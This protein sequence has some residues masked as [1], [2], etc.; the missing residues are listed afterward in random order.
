MK[1]IGYYV[2]AALMAASFSTTAMTA[3][4]QQLEMSY[5]AGVT[6]DYVWRGISQT[7]EGPAAQAG[8]DAAY[9]LFYAGVWGSNVDF[10]DVGVAS[11]SADWEV[12]LVAG[13]KPKLGM[14]DFDLGLIYYMYP[15]ASDAAAEYN[16]LELKAGVSTSIDKL[17]VG[18]TVYYSPETTAKGGNTWVYEGTAEYALPMDFAISGT[19]GGYNYRDTP[20]NDYTYWNI[21]LSKSFGDHWSVDARYWD[22]DKSSTSCITNTG[23]V[24][25]DG[26]FVASVNFSF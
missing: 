21:G 5:N 11:S 19:V 13:I 17:T 23:N 14:F 22:T 20:A 26:R 3:Q 6:S 25:C 2:S 1:R 18:G 4:A 10:G 7:N 16:F 15:G 9:G 24:T 12:D 8:I